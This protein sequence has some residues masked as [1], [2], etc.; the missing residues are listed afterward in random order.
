MTTEFH[1]AFQ[2]LQQAGK[3]GRT[4]NVRYRQ[5]ELY[6]LHSALRENLE[7]IQEAITEDYA[8]SRE[9]AET[10][11][12]LVLDAVQKSYDSLDFEKSLEH[13]YLVKF[14]KNNT[15]R[16]A[17]TG[18]VT[19][20]PSKHSRFYSVMVALAAAIEA[21]NCVVVVVGILLFS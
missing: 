6:A 19:I 7:I 20:W 15:E 14:G 17:P 13:E 3:D 21:E 11:V 10:E 4:E 9:K 1:T 2:R 16:R 8:G 18:L 5:N 12:F